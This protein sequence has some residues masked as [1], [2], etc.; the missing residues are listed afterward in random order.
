MEPGGVIKGLDVIIRD[1]FW[2]QKV[3]GFEISNFDLYWLVLSDR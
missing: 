1:V 2:F 3:A